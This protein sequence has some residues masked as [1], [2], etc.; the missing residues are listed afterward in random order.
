MA[1][2]SVIKNDFL[3]VKIDS[4][5]AELRSILDSDGTERLWQGDEAWWD[6][7]APHLFPICG[8]MYEGRYLCGGKSYD[9]RNHGFA[10]RSLFT[11][12][13]LEKDKAVY[14]LVSNDETKAVYPFDFEFRVTY[15][16]EGNALAVTYT[17]N[18]KTDGDIY[19]SIGSHEAYMCEGGTVDYNIFFYKKE[20]LPNHLLNGP[21]LNGKVEDAPITD[22]VMELIDSE[23]ARLDTYI[24]R[25]TLSK[26]VTLKKQGSE[27]SITVDF[28]ETPNVLIWKEP[29]APFI[30]I[31]PWCGVPDHDGEVRELSEK[32]GIIKLEKNGVFTNTHTIIID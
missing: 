23:F 28:S 16:L 27:K 7:Y 6:G 22:G 31:E 10:K 5:G 11:I 9:I 12:E 24:F 25:D 2:I 1:D 30:C 13:T 17:V 4:F 14:L 3:T 26:R 32:D 19:F 8:C 15:T 29:N 20:T 21:F 18:N